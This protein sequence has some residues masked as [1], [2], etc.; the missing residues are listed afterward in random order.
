MWE[1]FSCGR[2]PYGHQDFNDV[3]ALLEDPKYKLPCPLDNKSVTGWDPED[4]YNELS[5][6]CFMRD[7][8]ERPPFSKVIESIEKRLTGKE[9]LYYA[10][11]EEKY[12][13]EYCNIY[14]KFGKS[15]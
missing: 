5:N 3:L 6:M 7:P 12:Q 9:M 8:N 4:L 13:S 1:M 14:M 15:K 11:M 2:T 10:N